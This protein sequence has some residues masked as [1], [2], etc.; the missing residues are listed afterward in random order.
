MQTRIAIVGFCLGLLFAGSPSSVALGATGCSLDNPQKDLALFF[1]SF[2][3]F[4]V[5]YLTFANQ[6]PKAHGTLGERLGGDLDQVYETRDVPYTLYSVYDGQ[7][8]LG[9]VFGTN[10]RG[11]YSNIQVIAATD[12]LGALEKVYIQKIRSPKSQLFLSDEFLANLAS[13]PLETY[14]KLG[15]CLQDKACTQNPILDPSQGAESEDYRAILRGMT[16]LGH[17]RELLLRPGKTPSPRSQKARGEFV[18]LLWVPEQGFRPLIRP[19]KVPISTV[20]TTHLAEDEPVAVVIGE[21]EVTLYPISLLTLHPVMEDRLD[22]KE[23]TVA[24]SSPTFTLNVLAAESN[25]PLRFSNSNNV[26]FGHQTLLERTSREEW[27]PVLGTRVGIHEGDV[28]LNAHSPAWIMPW[29]DAYLAFPAATVAI[30]E[31]GYS[32]HAQFYEAHKSRFHGESGEERVLV[33]TV[34]GSHLPIQKKTVRSPGAYTFLHGKKRF[35]V[36]STGRWFTA[37]EL[38]DGPESETAKVEVSRDLTRAFPLLS[39]EGVDTSWQG[40]TGIGVSGKQRGST[41]QAI[42][43]REFPL[44]TAKAFLGRVEAITWEEPQEHAPLEGFAPPRLH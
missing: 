26:L 10:Q 41:L 40:T 24:W 39:L 28:T 18:S 21:D 37:F 15:P 35:V 31:D 33:A 13:V 3:H 6:N 20:K 14:Q 7:K 27:C 38:P 30:T 25:P 2:S 4:T 8:T 44:A 32:K 23:I 16:K 11:T 29:A 36:L 42:Q 19:K 9:Y 17:V 34:D 12:A 5:Q 1:P 22:G 43:L